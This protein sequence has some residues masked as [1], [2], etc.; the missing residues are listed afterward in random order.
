MVFGECEL[1]VGDAPDKAKAVREAT[2]A[3]QSRAAKA[4]SAGRAEIAAP[5]LTPATAAPVEGGGGEVTSEADASPSAKLARRGKR[6][7]DSERQPE[8]T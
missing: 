7:G 1:A 6:T 2:A 8:S 3:P 4:P 5:G